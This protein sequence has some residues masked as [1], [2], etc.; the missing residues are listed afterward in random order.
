VALGYV[1]TIVAANW[2]T[3]RWP[4][5]SVLAL[6][7]PGG[8]AAAGLAFTFR[9]LLQDTYGHAA[10]LV[11]IAAGTGLAWLIA[12]PRIATAS[13]LAFAASE[14]TAFVIYTVL[15]HRPRL[16]AVGAANT[17]NSSPTAHCAPTERCPSPEACGHVTPAGSQL[18][19]TGSWTNG[20]WPR[21]YAQRFRRYR[22][23]VD[24]LLSERRVRTG[25]SLTRPT[26][27]G[28]HSRSRCG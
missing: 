3:T 25:C 13:M 15:R 16:V 10:V 18:Q 26:G 7:N 17:A 9:N 27:V 22:D 5:L 24:G 8:S 1:A 4:D 14:C 2:A 11:A 6:H 19:R 20:P 23:E 28:G 12:S 21:E